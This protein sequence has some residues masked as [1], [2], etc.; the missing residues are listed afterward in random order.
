MLWFLPVTHS[1]ENKHTIWVLS[2]FSKNCRMPKKKK[3]DC[4]RDSKY[5]EK[6][7]ENRAEMGMTDN[8]F[9]WGKSR[10]NTAKTSQKKK[11]KHC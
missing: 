3:K 5:T 6:V 7:N 11:K 4:W 8:L 9:H 10:W 2:S 1:T